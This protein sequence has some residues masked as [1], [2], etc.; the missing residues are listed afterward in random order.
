MAYA[1]NKEQI[2]SNAKILKPTAFVSTE[3][4]KR[5]LESMFSD[6]KKRDQYVTEYLS[7]CAANPLIAQCDPATSFPAFLR[8]KAMGL[9]YGVGQYDVLPYWDG[10]RGCYVAQFQIGAKG[11]RQLATRSGVYRDVAPIAVREG[12]YKGRNKYTGEPIVEFEQFEDFSKPIVGYFAYAIKP[13]E[14]SP[15]SV[16]YMTK[17]EAFAHGKHYS[18]SF[19]SGP[20]KDDFDKMALKTVV[21]RLCSQKLVLSTEVL[22]A[23]KYDQAVLSTESDDVEYIDNPN[24]DKKEAEVNEQPLEPTDEDVAS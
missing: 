3:G 12:E 6:P 15:C 24:E 23:I 9:A 10:K 21:K 14:Q 8:G 22:E 7:V 18:K 5:M 2:K 1:L 11:Y 16:E 13:G 4:A 17:E 19:N 20:W